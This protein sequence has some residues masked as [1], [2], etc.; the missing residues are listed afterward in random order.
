M[1]GGGGLITLP[2]LI[3]AGLPATVANGT[4]RLAIALQNITALTTFER[5][6]INV[7]RSSWPLIIPCVLGAILGV[8][9]ALNIDEDLFRRLIGI[10]LL[11]MLIPTLIRRKPSG[12]GRKDL[13]IKAWMW[14]AFFL[15][16]VYGGFLQAGVGFIFVITLIGL[17]GMNWVHGNAT[18]VLLVLGYNLVALV[19]FI[20]GDRF[21]WLP[22]ITLAA[23]NAIGGWVGAHLTIH[24]GESW[25][26]AVFVI[27]VVLSA[28]KLLGVFDWLGGFLEI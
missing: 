19:L 25:I 28:L 11:V 22:A 13:Q 3:F 24:K 15:I 12:E 4:Y 8:Q 20:V 27:A 18:K 17:A 16:G 5:R 2:L 26:R 21:A 1:A 10:V 14:P 23:G 7:T 9:L 6:G